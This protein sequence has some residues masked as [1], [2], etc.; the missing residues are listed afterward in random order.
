[1][2]SRPVGRV[3]VFYMI[4]SH[5]FTVSTQILLLC[6]YIVA[7]IH[8]LCSLYQMPAEDA[9]KHQGEKL[10]RCFPMLSHTVN[11]TNMSDISSEEKKFI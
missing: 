2:G 7:H 1:M 5:Y 9:L 4:F 11:N 8:K 3:N 10:S 6:Y